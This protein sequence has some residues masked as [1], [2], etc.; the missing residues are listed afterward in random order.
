MNENPE[1]SRQDT[2]RDARKQI[3]RSLFLALAALGVIVFACYAWF[4]STTSVTGS[5]GSVSL[6]SGSFELASVGNGGAFDDQIP[7]YDS[8]I[9]DEWEHGST[10]YWTTAGNKNAVLWRLNGD[11]H[12]NNSAGNTG[13]QPGDSGTLQFYVIPKTTGTLTLTFHLQLIP[14]VPS[15][16]D[17][18][19][20][21]YKQSDDSLA[22][23][24]LRGHLLFSYAVG[25]EAEN[26]GSFQLVN[27][28]TGS[29]QLVFSDVV[30]DDPIP[31]TIRWIWP[32]LLENVLNDDL[33]IVSSGDQIRGW[34]IA[35]P[36]DFFYN[37]G[38]A[39][40]A[41][42]FGTQSR[43]YNNYFNNADQYIG[44]NVDAVLLRMSAVEN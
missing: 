28:R 31:V 41:P 34:M 23:S 44:D 43:L 17:S 14:L 15:D 35:A 8:F 4:V 5:L 27:Y 6:N 22:S 19:S 13:I 30:E 39:I 25:Q 1:A 36:G 26:A 42:G 33:Y 20:S 38:N 7:E 3:T 12:L 29:F 32:Y 10:T 37:Q 16:P 40:P 9:P 2:I 24:L 18:P 21:E 11:S